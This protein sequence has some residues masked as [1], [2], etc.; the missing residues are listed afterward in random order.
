MTTL[1]PTLSTAVPRTKKK[2]ARVVRRMVW[3]A[4]AVAIAVAIALAA[5][6]RPISVEAIAV[7]RGDLVVTV[8]EMAKTRVRDRYLVSAPMAGNVLRIELRPGDSVQAGSVLARVAPTPPPLLD[9]RARVQAEA[10]VSSASAAQK[11]SLAA[12]A[13]AEVAAEHA[14][15]ELERT[16]SLVQSGSLAKDVLIDAE[17]AAR[18]RRE[19]LASARFASQMAAHDASMAAAA[20]RRFEVR[21]DDGFDVTSPVAG[22]VLRVA[23]PSGGV[24]MPGA[25]LVEIG[26]PAGLEVVADVLTADAVRMHPGAK[27]TVHRWGGT[28]LAAHVRTIEPSAFTRMSALGVEEQR[29]AVVIDLDEPRERW[30]ALGD[31]YRVEV[32]ILITERKD[33]VRVPL[34]ATF[35]HDGAWAAYGV[36]NGK[37]ELV[38]LELGA[39]SDADV[40][41]VSGLSRGDVVVLHPSERVVQGARV[42]P[43]P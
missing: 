19:E 35:R 10:R 22:R 15:K 5:R 20:L 23:Q 14:D 9:P 13:R 25:P 27:V 38:R 31:G 28:P 18:M 16:R 11:Q 32:R 1:A 37:A 24:I 8:D 26:D 41:V 17:L 34:G 36:K 43:G 6:P 7:Q 42:E 4:L 21:S 39:R 2:R 40:E 3:I 30:A 33:V 12:V 29:V